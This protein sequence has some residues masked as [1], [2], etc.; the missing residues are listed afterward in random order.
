MRNR[1]YHLGPRV[2]VYEC[3]LIWEFEFVLLRQETSW[4]SLYCLRLVLLLENLLDFE[5]NCLKRINALNK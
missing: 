2:F 4:Y 1:V 5:N 3:C